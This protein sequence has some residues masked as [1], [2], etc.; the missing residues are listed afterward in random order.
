MLDR[1]IR[2]AADIENLRK[3]QKILICDATHP[4]Q[5]T[6]LMLIEHPDSLRWTKSEITQSLKSTAQ[7]HQANF[8][9]ECQGL[10]LRF[11]PPE[12]RALIYGTY[13]DA[14]IIVEANTNNDSMFIVANPT[15]LPRTTKRAIEEVAKA[16]NAT[17]L[18]L[19]AVLMPLRT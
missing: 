6:S 4:T 8:I 13:P 7:F 19:A 14:L 12:A 5:E 11:P 18:H 17:P 1:P 16:A 2:L 3:Q 9:K 10:L 15:A